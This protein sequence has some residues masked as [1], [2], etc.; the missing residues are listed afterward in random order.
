M[1]RLV[2]ASYYMEQDRWS[3]IPGDPYPMQQ[4][5]TRSVRM[6]TFPQPEGDVDKNFAAALAKCQ[7]ALG[8]GSGAVT[9]PA[10]GATRG[11]AEPKFM[12]Q[13]FL[14]GTQVE[15][16]GMSATEALEKTFECLCE[17]FS[18]QIT[19]DGAQTGRASIH[20]GVFV[21]VG[22]SLLQC[23]VRCKVYRTDCRSGGG[24]CLVLEITRRSGDAVAFSH[25]SIRAKDYLLGKPT[26]EIQAPPPL[27]SLL[28]KSGGYDPQDGMLALLRML[29]EVE[30][31]SSAASLAMT[32]AVLPTLV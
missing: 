11:A 6:D 1:E 9:K 16:G 2:E 20:A 7:D 4:E 15:L 31:V 25:A 10:P 27:G 5:A 30:G 14:M 29:D 19:K 8:H 22:G 32:V 26:S 12:H 21:P 3:S 17:E 13:R 23:T 24:S 18:A 28:A